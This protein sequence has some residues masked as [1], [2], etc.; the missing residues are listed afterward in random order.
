MRRKL[1]FADL[2][3]SVVEELLQE[4][5]PLEIALK[6]ELE[7]C[8]GNL[9]DIISLTEL[10]Q[11]KKK[12]S[13]VARNFHFDRSMRGIKVFLGVVFFKSFSPLNI[14]KY[15]RYDIL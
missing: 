8:S 9:S 15:Y 6:T 10:K 3:E 7:N 13:K 2:L 12:N 4:I 1:F 14:Y 5:V 11:D